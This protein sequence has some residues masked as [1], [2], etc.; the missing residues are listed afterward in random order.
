ME[1][2]ASHILV[3]EKGLADDLRKRLKS[4]AKFRDLAKEFSTCPS[5]SKSGDLGW[6]G[7][8]K[9]VKAFEEVVKRMGHGRI[10]NGVNTQFGYHII[11]LEE[12]RER[13]SSKFS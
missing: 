9:M 12:K 5:K 8:G 2:R 4:G 13:V 10:S 3:K 6:F 11:L 1:W 7:P